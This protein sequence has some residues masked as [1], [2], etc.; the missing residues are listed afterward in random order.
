MFAKSN[1]SNLPKLRLVGSKK[2][3]VDLLPGQ[4]SWPQ[5]VLEISG[6]PTTPNLC[7]RNTSQQG[8]GPTSAQCPSPLKDLARQKLTR[9]QPGADGGCTRTRASS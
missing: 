6:T 3:R 1:N 7:S 9:Q 5:G 4:Y 2:G 8:C